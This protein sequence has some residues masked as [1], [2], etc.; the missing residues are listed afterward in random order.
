MSK[1][2]VEEKLRHQGS[3]VQRRRLCREGSSCL[4][5][6]AGRVPNSLGNVVNSALR[7]GDIVDACGQ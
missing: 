4:R 6:P 1:V 7:I 3:P 2:A 5:R